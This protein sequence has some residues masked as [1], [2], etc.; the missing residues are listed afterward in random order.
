MHSCQY[1]SPQMS[2]YF[3]ILWTVHSSL[4]TADEVH[5]EAAKQ[6]SSRGGWTHHVVYWWPQP[7]GCQST[8]QSTCTGRVS[9]RVWSFLLS[10]AIIKWLRWAWASLLVVLCIHVP[11]APV[12]LWIGK[13]TSIKYSVGLPISSGRHQVNCMHV[14]I[15]WLCTKWMLVSPQSYLRPVLSLLCGNTSVS[16]RT[17]VLKGS[18]AICTTMQAEGCPWWRHNRFEEPSLHEVSFDV[19]WA[20]CK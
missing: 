5:C 11:P 18:H 9:S 7:C 6:G 3:R 1:G 12:V 19:W 13:L 8:A 14:Q 4:S 2:G 10:H 16:K 15:A 20:L 17:T